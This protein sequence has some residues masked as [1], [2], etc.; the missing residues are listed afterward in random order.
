MFSYSAQPLCF[1]LRGAPC[2]ASKNLES[3]RRFELL[4][5][6]FVCNLAVSSDAAIS[7]MP[8]EM[9]ILEI[10]NESCQHRRW[11]YL[12]LS[13]YINDL[14]DTWASNAKQG[15]ANNIQTACP[16]YR[17][18]ELTLDRRIEERM[19]GRKGWVHLVSLGCTGSHLVSLGL[20]GR[21]W[22]HWSHWTYYT[23]G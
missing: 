3:I 9:L 2:G 13:L 17:Q 7:L 4:Y 18:S 21:N 14:F 20:T 16:I 22:S 8:P 15:H 5:F 1:L 10:K 12:A 11:I 6:M 23:Q 19:G